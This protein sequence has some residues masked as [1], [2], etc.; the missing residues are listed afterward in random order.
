MARPKLDKIVN[1]F[2]NGKDF[3][4]TRSQ[5]ISYTGADI[6]QNKRYTEEKSAIARKAFEYGYEV[7]VI[8]ERLEFHKVK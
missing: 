2:D 6:P 3:E 8:P 7:K 5:Y 1:L 4:M